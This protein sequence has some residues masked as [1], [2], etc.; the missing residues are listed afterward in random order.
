MSH[1][2]YGI[3]DEYRKQF[4][5]QTLTVWSGA[6]C[7][8]YEGTAL[9]LPNH[10]GFMLSLDSRQVRVSCPSPRTESN[11]NQVDEAIRKAIG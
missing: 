7:S 11:F 1:M 2:T 5:R 6:Y 3:R 8:D 9:E 10:N 4:G